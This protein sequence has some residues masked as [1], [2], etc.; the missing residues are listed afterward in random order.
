ME[1]VYFPDETCKR[2]ALPDDDVPRVDDHAA[3]PAQEEPGH[4]GR[5][6][7]VSHSVVRPEN[8]PSAFSREQQGIYALPSDEANNFRSSRLATVRLPW[9][10]ILSLTMPDLT[11]ET[12]GATPVPAPIQHEGLPRP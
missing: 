4:G 11:M 3:A 2:G 12:N 5:G 10:R 9:T 1:E 6:R 8:M 7:E